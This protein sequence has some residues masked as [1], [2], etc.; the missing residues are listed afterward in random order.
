MMNY[1]LQKAFVICFFSLAGAI[2][3]VGILWIP[4]W[5][6]FSEIRWICDSATIS[7][8]LNIEY[9]EET[10]TK[11]DEIVVHYN[12]TEYDNASNEFLSYYASVH[13]SCQETNPQGYLITEIATIITDGKF[14]FMAS[15]STNVHYFTLHYYVTPSGEDKPFWDNDAWGIKYYSFSP[16]SVDSLIDYFAD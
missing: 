8:R 12:D 13:Q 1:K 16:S 6:L 9:F 5:I 14:T 7:E 3:L 15:Y 11:S 10:I 2:F 4:T